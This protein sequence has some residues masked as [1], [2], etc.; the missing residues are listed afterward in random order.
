LFTDRQHTDVATA[1]LRYTKSTGEWAIY[2]RD[3]NLKFHEY[4]R[5][6]TTKSVQTF[7][8]AHRNQ[9]RPDLLGLTSALG[10]T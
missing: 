6:R 3:R 10:V 7:P 5:K 9:R 1:R 8:R 4:K 2:W